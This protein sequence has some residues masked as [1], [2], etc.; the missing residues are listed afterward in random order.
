MDLAGLGPFFSGRGSMNIFAF[1]L[2]GFV[3]KTK[4]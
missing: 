3:W 1:M 4:V 2:K